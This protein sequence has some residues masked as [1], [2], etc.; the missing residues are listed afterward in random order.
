M[1]T[2]HIT[3]SSAA[4]SGKSRVLYLI[5][6]TLRNRGF[7]VKFNGG[8]DFST[9]KSFDEQMHENIYEVIDSI[10]DM[11]EIVIEEK[12]LNRNVKE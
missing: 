4:G 5:K 8:M 11:S 2:I 12:Q 9:E 3:V 7:D 10:A 6:E 1:K